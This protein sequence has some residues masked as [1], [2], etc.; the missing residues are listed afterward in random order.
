M[1]LLRIT[2]LIRERALGLSKREKGQREKRRLA[3]KMRRPDC[4]G[5]Y[6][7]GEGETATSATTISLASTFNF[8]EVNLKPGGQWP[9]VLKVRGE[10]M[11]ANKGLQ[12]E[13]EDKRKVIMAKLGYSVD[14]GSNKVQRNRG[15]GPD[16]VLV[17]YEGLEG[18]LPFC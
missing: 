13:E 15:L 5:D 6:N 16:S 2:W 17:G 4:K 1:K 12:Q 3:G 11:A 10:P 7:A 14:G 9:L 8:R 18:C